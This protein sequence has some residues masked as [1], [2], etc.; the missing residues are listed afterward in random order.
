MEKYKSQDEIRLEMR[1][2]Y[3]KKSNFYILMIMVLIHLL[4]GLMSELF[5]FLFTLGGMIL[6]PF[7]VWLINDNL[8]TF[9]LAVLLCL[10]AHFYLYKT[11]LKDLVDDIE[12]IRLRDEM[13]TGLNEL[14]I[15]LRERKTNKAL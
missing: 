14:W 15:I 5:I 3:G 10:P 4:R 12:R 8:F 1:N 9:H 11:D 7:I 13:K 6:I 2:D